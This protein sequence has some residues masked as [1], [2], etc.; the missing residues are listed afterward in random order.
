MSIV[1]LMFGFRRGATK[2]LKEPSL[3]WSGQ[4]SLAG[5]GRMSY[6]ERV[7]WLASGCWE[8]SGEGV[9]VA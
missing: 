8:D 3:T 4:M 5:A 7:P 6:S 9:E 1:E 2:A